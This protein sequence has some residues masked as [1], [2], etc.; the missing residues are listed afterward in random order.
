MLDAI[1]NFR[2]LPYSFRNILPYSLSLLFLSLL[3]PGAIRSGCAAV[4]WEQ[5]KSL[6]LAHISASDLI[7]ELGEPAKYSGLS[8]DYEKDNLPSAYILNYMEGGGGYLFT[9]IDDRVADLRIYDPAYR[10]NDSIHIGVSKDDA[11][12]AFGPPR[13]TQ[14]VLP[15]QF[16]DRFFYTNIPGREW[17]S[18]YALKKEGVLLVFV[19]DKLNLIQL[20]PQDFNPFEIR[21]TLQR[22]APGRQAFVPT[23]EAGSVQWKGDQIVSRVLPYPDFL[24]FFMRLPVAHAAATGEGVRISILQMDSD[25][26]VS[27]TVRMA[28]PNAVIQFHACRQSP[29]QPLDLLEEMGREAPKIVLIPDPPQWDGE[30]LLSL[31]RALIEIDALPVVPGDL[32]AEEEDIGVIQRLHELGCMTIGRLSWQSSLMDDAGKPFNKQIQ[33]IPID[34]FT[35]Q[36]I[37]DA[38]ADAA[39]SA[40]GA[41]ALVREK[42]PDQTAS[43]IRQILLQG[44][45]RVWHMK[46]IQ[47]E[48]HFSNIEQDPA[49]GKFKRKN[50]EAFFEFNILDAPAAL[51]V[52]TEI[53]WFLNA[54]NCQKAWEI[55]QGENAVA[56][57]TDQGFHIHHPRLKD[58]I[59][60]TAH[61]GPRTFD[62]PNMNFHGTEMSRILLAVAPKAKLIPIL[63]SADSIQN[64]EEYG[65]NIAESFRYAAGEQADVISASWAGWFNTDENVIQAIQD[66][67]DR[68]VTVSWFHFP[69]AHP[70]VLRPSFNYS[71]HGE[72]LGFFDRYMFGEWETWPVDLSCGLS[73]TAPQAAGIAAL[74]RSVN[75]DLTPAGIT[76]LIQR[77]STPIGKQIFIPDAYEIVKQAK[78]MREN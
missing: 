32:S 20:F 68:G 39:A 70:G 6:D 44:S 13:E 19:E 23:K 42:R 77:N 9:I 61:F 66:A 5:V 48:N 53:P 3:L 30:A 49:T 59:I 54:L 67:V 11:F 8:I 62:S 34:L 69:D 2:P 38:P 15:D 46:S 37:R 28:A 58:S 65:R 76:D 52:D 25:D 60:Q 43:E 26:R 55:T 64:R 74:V 78:E 51:G 33:S 31:A 63:C 1:K 4:S 73:N 17:M 7:R 10:L 47:G 14:P 75:P 41:A 36:G 18:F 27:A 22:T 56:A 24:S 35:T 71:S 29:K 40:A 50:K 45:Q 12:Q 21:Q 72:G 57:V 16:E